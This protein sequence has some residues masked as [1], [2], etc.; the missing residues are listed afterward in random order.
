MTQTETPAIATAT[1][2]PKRRMRDAYVARLTISIPLDMT[3]P[4]SFGSAAEAI[5]KLG[6]G[7]PT[8]SKFES[9]ARIG[10]VEAA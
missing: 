6:I 1:K 4:T 9:E 3:D 2:K 10:K 8:G 7:L 5:N